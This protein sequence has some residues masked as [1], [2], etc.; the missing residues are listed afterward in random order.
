MARRTAHRLS[1]LRLVNAVL[2]GV[3]TP[4]EAKAL[5]RKVD[6]ED[7]F[8]EVVLEQ[9]TNKGLA[10]P[11]AVRQAQDICIND[12]SPSAAEAE[13]PDDEIDEEYREYGGEG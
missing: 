4:L 2:S 7:F 12:C 13:Q 6:K 9:A 3:I 5:L 11:S 10:L 1:G 8:D